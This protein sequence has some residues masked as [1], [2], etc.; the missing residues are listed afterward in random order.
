MSYPISKGGRS[1]DVADVGRVRV[2]ADRAQEVPPLIARISRL[3][4]LEIV[5]HEARLEVARLTRLGIF[6]S[7]LL[8]SALEALAK[9]GW[10]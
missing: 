10:P 6:P 1:L 5:A 3:P 9:A 2:D 7:E 8:V 4:E